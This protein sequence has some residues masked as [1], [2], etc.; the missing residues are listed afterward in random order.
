MVKTSNLFAS[1]PSKQLFGMPVKSKDLTQSTSS[2][3]TRFLETVKRVPARKVG[4]ESGRLIFALD[5]TLSRMPTWDMATHIQ[6]E[7]FD[8]T[9]GLGG[10]AIQL[11]YYRG[12]QE[13]SSS[14]WCNNGDDLRHQ[15][16]QVRCAGGQTQIQRVLSHCLDEHRRKKI[17]G[18]IFVGDAMEENPDKLCD[19]AGKMG[20]SKI[21]AFMFQEGHDLLTQRTFKEVARLSGGAYAPF[22]LSSAGELKSL[23]SAVAVYAAGGHKA[24]M[25]LKRNKAAG[26]LT[27]QLKD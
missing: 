22:N 17:Q 10:L 24:L 4:S 2:D 13:F 25:N 18:L 15:M 14:A 23:L 6:N 5:A 26:L 9:T 27:R 8:A 20:I 7:M 16:A 11:C 3:V 12:F 21:P 19:L 1:G